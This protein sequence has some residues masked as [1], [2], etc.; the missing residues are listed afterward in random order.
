M[1]D[2]LPKPFTRKSLL[3]MLEKH[4]SHL[5][6][7]PPGMEP[8][9]SATASSVPRSSTAHSIK[10]DASSPAQSPAGS[11]VNWQSPG[12]YPGVSPIHTNIPNQYVQMPNH[13]PYSTSPHTPLAS[14]VPGRQQQPCQ[15]QQQHRR[16][17]SELSGGA[18][19]LNGYNNKRQRVYGQPAQNMGMPGGPLC[20]L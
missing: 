3:D 4:L 8:P 11:L 13:S 19:D 20:Q 18:P 7:I 15:P 10:D 1:D 2:V 5:K 17:V 9:S 6:K 14:T 12:Q 16:Q